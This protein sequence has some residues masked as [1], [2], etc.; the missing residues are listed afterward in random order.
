MNDIIIMASLYIFI[1]NADWL[2]DFYDMLT[3]LGLF[4]A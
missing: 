1:L 2:I 4:Y 3:H